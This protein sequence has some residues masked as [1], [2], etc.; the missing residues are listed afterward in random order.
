MCCISLHP[1]RVSLIYG[2]LHTGTACS[3]IKIHSYYGH[4]NT[5]TTTNNTEIEN[6]RHILGILFDSCQHHARGYG[7]GK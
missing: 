5:T 6:V 4:N 2:L 3:I 1:G 7:E